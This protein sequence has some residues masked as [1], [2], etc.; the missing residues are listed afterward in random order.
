LNGSKAAGDENYYNLQS[1]CCYKLAEKINENGIYIAADI[2]GSEREEII[3][4]LEQL[5]SYDLD[6]GG[7][8][9]VLPKAKIKENIGRSPDWRDMLMMRMYFELPH[10]YNFSRPIKMKF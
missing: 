5:K 3:E 2:E 4:E 8:L 6:K 9:R 1:Q 10:K 7:K